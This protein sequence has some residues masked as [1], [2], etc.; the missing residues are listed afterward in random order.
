VIAWPPGG[1]SAI[2]RRRRQGN[3][4]DHQSGSAVVRHSQK[5]KGSF[6]HWEPLYIEAQRLLPGGKLNQPG[7]QALFRA[8]GWKAQAASQQRWSARVAFDEWKRNKFKGRK[9]GPWKAPRRFS[10]TF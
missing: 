9:G 2:L 5:K 7:R 6:E 3:H 10:G 1:S 8:Y 4:S